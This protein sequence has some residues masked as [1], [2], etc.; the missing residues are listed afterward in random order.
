MQVSV[1]AGGAFRWGHGQLEIKC[2]AGSTCNT[3]D[4]WQLLG[5]LQHDN[6][7]VSYRMTQLLHE[8]GWWH[9]MHGIISMSDMMLSDAIMASCWGIVHQ[10]DSY[11]IERCSSW[12]NLTITCQV[13]GY[14]ADDPST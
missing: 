13:A 6:Y 14:I 1:P 2:P 10:R 8:A 3:T 5:A 9:W 4:G 7:G 11:P 12:L